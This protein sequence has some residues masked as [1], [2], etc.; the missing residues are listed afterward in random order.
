MRSVYYSPGYGM[1]PLRRRHVLIAIGAS[2]LAPLARSQSAPRR[3]AW[4]GP[5]RTEVQSPYLQAMRAGLRERGWEEGRNIALTTHFTDGTAEA[6]E[7]VAQHMIASK[8]EII[9]AYGGDV[10]SLHRAKPSM[11]VVFAQSGDPTDAG[12]VQSLA[13][14]GGNFTGMTF[15]SV[16]LVGKRIEMLREFVPNAR[17]LAVL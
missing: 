6:S 4:Y 16:D 8:Q 10:V 9:I 14:P 13:R 2:Y 7:L 3:I 15:L 5:G 1:S 12:F 17:R 11:P